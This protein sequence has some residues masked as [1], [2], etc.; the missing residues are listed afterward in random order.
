MNLVALVAD[1]QRDEG[2]SGYLYD[3]ATGQKIGPG[4][5][6]K[7]HPT[8]GYGF[9]LD[10]S[11]LTMSEAEPI[12]SGRAQAAWDYLL[13]AIPWAANLSE[14]RQRALANM[15]Y[16]LGTSGLLEFKEFLALLE[17]GQYE[18]AAK[19]LATTLWFKQSGD[20]APRIQALIRNG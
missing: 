11:P 15:A 7:G 8:V 5:S 3:D 2:W 19:D 10:V 4:S 17:K 18:V 16:Q 20:R 6:V 12:L 1:L 13:A 14:P 9:A